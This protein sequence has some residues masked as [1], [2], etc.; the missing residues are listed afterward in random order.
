MSHFEGNNLDMNY[1]DY[2]MADLEPCPNKNAKKSIA[3]SSLA[4]VK[5][6][7]Q[8]LHNSIKACIANI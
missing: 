3:E 7:N 8:D 1:F 6:K 5:S 2:E 4:S